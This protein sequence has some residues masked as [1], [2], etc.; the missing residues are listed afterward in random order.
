M[1]LK[2]KRFF[3][4]ALYIILCLLV[5]ILQASGLFT[6]QIATASAVLILPMIIYGGFYFG[7]FTGALIGFIGGVLT[8]A[9]S[10]TAYYNTI[11]LTICGF[12]CGMI[13]MYLFNRN[14]AA[15]FVLNPSVSFLY[16]FFKWLFVYAFKD[17]ASGFV[18]VNYTLPSFL[19]TAV[20]GVL[21]YFVFLPFFKKLPQSERK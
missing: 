18:L 21:M 12:A 3:F 4:F 11:A 15:A 1:P 14:F 5:I 6:L 7:C 10:S 16:F 19:Y 17:S 20:L 9:F 8:D 2:L 13:M